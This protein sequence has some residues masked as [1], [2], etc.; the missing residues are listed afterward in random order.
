[1]LYEKEVNT[2]VL[3][4]LVAQFAKLSLSRGSAAP[5]RTGTLLRGCVTAERYPISSDNNS[6]ELCSVESSAEPL[7]SC[8]VQSRLTSVQGGGRSL[9][10][11]E[12]VLSRE[13]SKG[14]L[15]SHLEKGA[16]TQ[17]YHCHK[18]LGFFP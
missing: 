14:D 4:W 16:E 6:G 1:M 8:H 5:S 15:S 2:H 7:Q 18:L 9:P 13:E 3:M 11:L 17:S 10:Q 12:S